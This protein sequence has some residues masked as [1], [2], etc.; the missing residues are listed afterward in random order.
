VTDLTKAELVAQ[1]EH[2]GIAKSGTKAELQ[3]RLDAHLA[4]LA[5][6]AAQVTDEDLTVGDW[7]GRPNYRCRYCPFASLR[8]RTARIHVADVHGGRR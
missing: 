8:K 2:F 1:A 5:R 6:R 3:A 7:K 4:D